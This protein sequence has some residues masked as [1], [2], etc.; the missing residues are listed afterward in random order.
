MQS[1]SVQVA[2]THHST[3][4]TLLHTIWHNSCVALCCI[5][6]TCCICCTC[7]IVLYLANVLHVLHVLHCVVSWL[8]YAPMFRL[9]R[10]VIV[11]IFIIPF[12]KRGESGFIF[13]GLKC[14]GAVRPH[15]KRTNTHKCRWQHRDRN[16]TPTH[17]SGSQVL[18]S[19]LPFLSRSSLP[20]FGTRIPYGREERERK[21]R[22]DGRTCGLPDAA[23]A[24]AGG[25]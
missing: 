15:P 11:A 14:T 19:H 3:S 16:P 2:V 5:L 4:Q 8:T 18:P 22:W 17:A 23:N 20:F 1:C 7:C 12:Q 13:R 25:T 6:P 9:C 24:A 10:G 21:G